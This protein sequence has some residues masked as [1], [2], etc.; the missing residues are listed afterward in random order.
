MFAAITLLRPAV[1]KY[2]AKPMKLNN[3]IA[4]CSEAREIEKYFTEL[5]RQLRAIPTVK[6][7]GSI[8]YI[9]NLVSKKCLIVSVIFQTK[10]VQSGSKKVRV[11]ADGCF[12]MVH[13]G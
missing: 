7:T 9:L 12:D 11:W 1:P 3:L 6:L 4:K 2:H 8:P 10:M 13:Y 5:D